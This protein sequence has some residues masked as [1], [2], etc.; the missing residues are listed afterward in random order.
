MALSFLIIIIMREGKGE[1]TRRE[2]GKNVFYYRQKLLP[3]VINSR[4][5]FQ[6]L[7][8]CWHDEWHRHQH[9]AQLQEYGH[10]LQGKEGNARA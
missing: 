1:S 5:F 7:L 3:W 4:H 9:A 6:L 10:G 2:E 8:R